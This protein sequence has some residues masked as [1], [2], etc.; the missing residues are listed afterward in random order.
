M[1]CRVCGKEFDR[2][3]CPNCG[4]DASLDRELIIRGCELLGMELKE[5]TELC[6]DGMR[7]HAEELGLMGTEA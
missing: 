5:V 3:P 4:Y 6:L 2:S 7:P 1:Q